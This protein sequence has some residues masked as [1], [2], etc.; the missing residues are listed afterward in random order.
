MYEY[1]KGGGFGSYYTRLQARLE[2]EEKQKRDSHR[3]DNGN[4]VDILDLGNLSDQE[5]KTY[6]A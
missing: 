4:K 1:Y 5:A 6:G 3:T 2:Q